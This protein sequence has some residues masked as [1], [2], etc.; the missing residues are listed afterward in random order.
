M[1]KDFAELRVLIPQARAAAMN[2][3][4]SVPVPHPPLDIESGELVK[5]NSGY[6]DKV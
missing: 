5:R 1:C 2:D 4:E 3:A 6:G